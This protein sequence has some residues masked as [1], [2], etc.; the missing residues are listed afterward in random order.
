MRETFAA[1]GA[2]WLCDMSNRNYFVFQFSE[3]P[4]S[5]TAEKLQLYYQTEASWRRKDALGSVG[6]GE[7]GPLEHVHSHHG[8]KRNRQQESK[9]TRQWP[10]FNDLTIPSLTLPTSFLEFYKIVPLLVIIII[11]IIIIIQTTSWWGPFSFSSHIYSIRWCIP[12]E[13]EF[14][15]VA[16]VLEMNI[17]ST[18]L[19]RT[20]NCNCSLKG[21]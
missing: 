16:G 14:V 8:R 9:T 2:W 11:I 7:E 13:L 3:C 20:P 18:L 19:V 1:S 4:L 5:L 15:E 10:T 17:S 6:C 12:E 21:Y